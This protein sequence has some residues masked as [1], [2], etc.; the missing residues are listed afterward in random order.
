MAYFRVLLEGNG[1]EIPIGSG[2]AVG[3]FVA[4]IVR[5][6]TETEA[7][8]RATSMVANEWSTRVASGG[9]PRLAVKQVERT[10]FFWGFLARQVNCTF[11][12][13]SY[14]VLARARLGA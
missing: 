1:I 14:S 11:F 6:K 8:S 12:S 13:A 9:A 7:V 5:A 2:K 10:T 4:R 3:F